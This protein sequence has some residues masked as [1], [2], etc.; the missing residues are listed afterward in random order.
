MLA[1]VDLAGEVGAAVAFRAVDGRG[2][3]FENSMAL[4]EFF[5]SLT[6]A[7]KGACCAVGHALS[8]GVEFQVQGAE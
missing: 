7:T 6:D 3:P 2:C 1:S 4:F 8:G 5:D